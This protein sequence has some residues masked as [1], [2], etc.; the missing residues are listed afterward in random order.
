MALKEK[1]SMFRFD[2]PSKIVCECHFLFALHVLALDGFSFTV[3]I[4]LLLKYLGLFNSNIFSSVGL[5]QE[6]E[7]RANIFIISV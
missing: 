6:L 1:S 2:F 7:I 3:R 4:Q 5:T